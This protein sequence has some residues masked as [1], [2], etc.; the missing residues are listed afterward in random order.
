MRTGKK[1][2]SWL[3]ERRMKLPRFG[4]IESVPDGNTV[5]AGDDR[6]GSGDRK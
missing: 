4:S 2:N 5:A 6:G 3:P 1:S